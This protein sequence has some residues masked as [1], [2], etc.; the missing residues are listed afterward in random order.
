[1]IFAPVSQF[2]VYFVLCLGA[3]CLKCESANNHFQPGEGWGLLYDCE[4][5]SNIRLKL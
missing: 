5:F 3:L 4:S 1:M 2:H